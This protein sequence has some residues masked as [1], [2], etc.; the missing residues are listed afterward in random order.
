MSDRGESPRRARTKTRTVHLLRAAGPRA[1]VSALRAARVRSA[2]RGVAGADAGEPFDGVWR[3]R[4][5][6]SEQSRSLAGLSGHR[7]CDHLFER[8]RPARPGDPVAVVD[9]VDGRSGIST[10]RRDP[11]RRMDRNG[12]DSRVA[13]RFGDSTSVRLDTGSRV[14]ALSSVIELAAGAV[15]VD[16]GRDGSSWRC[17]PQSPPLATS[18]RSSRF[19]CS[20]IAAASR[21][22]G[23]GPADGPGTFHHGTPGHGDHAVGERR[24]EPA[25]RGPRPRWE[26]TTR[27]AP[28]LEMEGTSLAR[29]LEHAAREQGWIVVPRSGAGPEAEAI[30]H[31]SVEG[32][33]ADEAVGVAV[34]TSGLRHRVEH[35]S[36]VV[37]R[38]GRATRRG[39][40][41]NDNVASHEG[42]GC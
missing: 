15:Y 39:R 7:R 10:E 31:G 41:H 16:N 19:A 24:G 33:A 6:F 37:F 30:L 25:V 40:P 5:L 21:A 20:G 22:N 8:R 11:D 29:F 3:A 34:A 18:A 42:G 9:Q 27:V 13:L 36:L 38:R 17:E 23:H 4:A 35:G 12:R 1:S 26:W 28:P 2:A 32:L 14:R